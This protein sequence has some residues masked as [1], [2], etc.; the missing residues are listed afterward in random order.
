MKLLKPVVFQSSQLISTTAT[1]AY[2]AWNSGT[3]Y[4]IGQRVT[5]GTRIYESL[6]NTNL[7]FQPDT[8]PTKWLDFAPG[9]KYAMFD[10]VVS[11]A[12]SN[13][14][15]LTVVVKPG[16]V[17]DSVALINV[18]ALTVSI[19]VRDGLAGPIVYEATAGL[20][21]AESFSWSDYFFTDPLIQRTQ[22]IF[23][24]IPGYVN[25]HITVVFTQETGVAASCG[26]MSYGTTVALGKTQYGASSGIIDYSI[27]QTDEFGNISF[28]ERAYSKRLNA[29][30][31]VNN[32]D[33]NRVQRTL[34]EV[35]A[36]PSV[37]IASDDPTYEES[38]IL[39]GYYKSF[40]TVIS[41]PTF[42]MLNIELEGLT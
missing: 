39:Y 32:A 5:Y 9:N 34:Y 4:S 22:I 15:S 11:T 17:I 26:V 18:S 33:I 30:V 12:T 19:T 8:N 1:E 21:G 14:T 36:R 40:D 2:S 3:T 31:F 16:V 10:D 28:V 38:C 42:N 24:G 6:V 20:S 41:Y 25:A 7:N 29:N 27:K 13:T 37:W 23:S 35:R